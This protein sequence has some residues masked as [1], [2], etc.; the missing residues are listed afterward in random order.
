MYAKAILKD[1]FYFISQKWLQILVL[2]L[3]VSFCWYIGSH[4][5]AGVLQE[6]QAMFA[7]LLLG[8]VMFSLIEVI[9]IIYAHGLSNGANPGPGVIYAAA[10]RYWLPM[11]QLALIKAILVG[12]GLMMLIIPGI[13]I[14]VRLSL[15]EQNLI[16]RGQGVLES[17][18][19]SS[20]MTAPHFGLILTVFGYLFLLQLSL[21]YLIT[22]APDFM[23]VVL[24]PA[25]VFITTVSTVA[26]YRI[27]VL[28]LSNNSTP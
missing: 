28:T 25:G 10:F 14:A 21:K 18:R 24:F 16:L 27:Y 8:I 6:M 22:L 7:E 20:T 13:F 23:D 11:I 1:C 19:S 4:F 15:A 26:A 5:I 17:L 2:I 3:P 9:V 12:A